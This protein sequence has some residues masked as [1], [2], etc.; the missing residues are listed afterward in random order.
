LTL[1]NK[2]QRLPIFINFDKSIKKEKTLI[3]K[4]NLEA[5]L[6]TLLGE[7]DFIQKYVEKFQPLKEKH[8]FGF[9]SGALELAFSS[10]LLYFS[11]QQTCESRIMKKEQMLKD[12]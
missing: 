5:I 11:Y 6:S 7:D 12:T 9:L 3:F 10:M 4:N 2:L 8:R 1:V